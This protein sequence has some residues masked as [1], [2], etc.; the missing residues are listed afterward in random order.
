MVSYVM[1]PAFC[2]ISML[3][4]DLQRSDSSHFYLS[5]KWVVPFIE[6]TIDEQQ[7]EQPGLM[8][9]HRGSENGYLVKRLES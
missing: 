6:G 9:V 1:V 7:T 2:D 5:L 3:D 4:L 8:H